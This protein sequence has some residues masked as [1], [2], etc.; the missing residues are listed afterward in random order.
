MDS[1]EGYINVES[2]CEYI[3]TVLLTLIDF[4]ICKCL[5]FIHSHEPGI[6]FSSATQIDDEFFF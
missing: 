4:H 6:V 3:V 1:V 2:N 5:P